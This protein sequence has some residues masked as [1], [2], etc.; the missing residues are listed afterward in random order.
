MKKPV[1]ALTMGDPAGVGP[2]IIVKALGRKDL[3]QKSRLILVGDIGILKEAAKR[4][5]KPAAVKALNKAAILQKTPVSRAA[6]KK[7]L[8]IL[9]L[10]SLDF[11]DIN[12]GRPGPSEGRAMCDYIKAAVNMA[13]KGAADAVVTC[14]V[15]KKAMLQGGSRFGGH[16]EMLASMS[17]S[18]H[19]VM[20]LANPGLRVALV[21]TH[22]PLKK[23]PAAIDRKKILD[24][25]MV[26]N[27]ELKDRLGIAKPQIIVAGLNP[28]AGEQ[29]EIGREEITIIGPAVQ[30]AR[31]MG[32]AVKGPLP[33][34]TVFTKKILRHAHAIVCMYH[35]Q[36]LIPVKMMDFENTVNITLGLPFV[37]TSVG[38][39]TAPDIAWKGK[40]SEKSLVQAL[41]S[42][43]NMAG[44]SG[45]RKA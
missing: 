1:L 5:A 43:V 36:G 37:R 15:N 8:H 31:D 9:S 44:K 45:T 2:E 16:T 20:M 26:V 38:H 34:D 39:G 24:T 33:P 30:N 22:L 25:I 23:V 6:I 14:P 42:A 32:V 13:M 40:A 10:S 35:D 3:L 41:L 18:K 19:A 21:T 27:K 28:H 29:G 7:G 11:R 4:F 12:P 17:R